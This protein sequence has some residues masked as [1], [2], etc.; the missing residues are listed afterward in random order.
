[1]V[2][3]EILEQSKAAIVG[4]QSLE[5]SAEEKAFF[6][7]VKPLGFILFA[8]NID[9]E[10]QVK[11]L[12]DSLR[13]CV[14]WDCPILIDQE[15]G[16]VARLRE[17]IAP[18]SLPFQFFGD[19]YKNDPE[20]AKEALRLNTEMQASYL[21]KLG[22]NVNCSPVLDLIVEGAHDIIGDRSFS[23]DP[24][25]I[26]DCS[27]VVCE[28]FLE[29]NITPISKHLPGH[30][31]ALCDSHEALPTVDLS[32]NELDETDFSPFVKLHEQSAFQYG[33]WS[34]VAHIVYPQLSGDNLP[35]TQSKLLV[36]NIIRDHMA[37]DTF[38]LADD[39]EMKALTGS[40][41]DKTKACL[42]AGMDVILACNYQFDVMKRILNVAT[43]LSDKSISR[44][45]KSEEE[46]FKSHKK[47]RPAREIEHALQTLI[48]S[49]K[50]A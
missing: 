5:L 11:S 39:I 17:P 36:D 27:S 30:G 15:G 1:M 24:H 19:L 14:G 49:A 6:S 10:D 44:F 12:T 20:K 33:V 2:G 21:R 50:A 38:L 34:M 9:T 26:F 47:P 29:F 43:R 8:R 45:L 28:T 48:S 22:I 13:E 4:V 42:D 16:R 41:E 31:R 3:R 40:V 18:T 23:K 25:I 7:D 46:R 37:I 32:L 35:A